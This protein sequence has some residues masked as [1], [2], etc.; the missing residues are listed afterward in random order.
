MPSSQRVGRSVGVGPHSGHTQTQPS[1]RPANQHST[2]TLIAHLHR[3]RC[4]ATSV[5]PNTHTCRAPVLAQP[6]PAPPPDWWP[7]M[8]NG[9]GA[10]ARRSR[11]EVTSVNSL[12]LPM[13]LPLGLLVTTFLCCTPHMQPCHAWDRDC[14]SADARRAFGLWRRRGTRSGCCPCCWQGSGGGGGIREEVSRKELEA[15]CT[16]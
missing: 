2:R 5:T 11:D 12:P 10:V 8:V 6:S 9:G 1:N 16:G 14:C 15:S 7:I 13:P 4:I 3:R